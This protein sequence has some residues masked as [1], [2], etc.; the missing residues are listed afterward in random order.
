MTTTTWTGSV[1]TVGTNASNWSNGLPDATKDVVFDGTAVRNCDASGLTTGTG[2]F[3]KTLDM[4]GFVRT[5]DMGAPASHTLRMKGNCT[6][7]GAATWTNRPRVQFDATTATL[8]T[9]G[10]ELAQLVVEGPN[11]FDAGTLTLNDNAL[12]YGTVLANSSSTIAIGTTTLTLHLTD[13][14]ASLQITG[15]GSFTYSGAGK[16]VIYADYAISAGEYYNAVP[17]I[18][19][20]STTTLPPV[21][22]HGS[23]TLFIAATDIYGGGGAPYLSSGTGNVT[24]QS[25]TMDAGKVVTPYDLAGA[26]WIGL[27]TVGNFTVS[28]GSFYQGRYDA[29][30]DDFTEDAGMPKSVVVGG[31]S[32][33]SV[34]MNGT[35]VNT[36][37]LNVTGTNVNDGGGA[38]TI[39][40]INSTGT[41]LSAA[42]CVDGGGNTGVSFSASNPTVSN[43]TS[44]HA[45]GTFGLG[46]VVD[47]TV[48]FSASVTVTGTP[49]LRLALNNGTSQANYLSGSGTDTLTFRYTIAAGDNT[50]DLDYFATTSLTLNGGTINATSGGASATLTL[51]SP[52]AAGSLGANR[53]IVIETT[54]P[55]VTNVTSAHANGSFK[56]AEVIDITIDFTEAVTVTGTPQLALNSGATV[57]YFSGSGSSTLTFR[58]TVAGGQ[59]SADLDYNATSSLTLNGGTIKDAAGNNA[60]LTLAT[61]GAA[62]SLGANKAIVIDTTAPTVSNVTSAHANGSFKVG[63]VIDITVQ[64]SETVTVTGTPQLALNTGATINY[65]S[66][67]GSNTLTFRYTVGSSQNTSDLDYAATT[68]LT[69]NSGTI[70]DAAGNNAT[71]TLASPG[72]AGSLGA[73]KAIII[74]TTAPTVLNV[75]SGHADGSFKSGEVVDITVQFSESVTVTGTPQLTLALSPNRAINYISGS[76]SD[77]L[78]FRLT[79]GAPDTS[80][81]LDYAATGSLGLNGGT[82]ADAAGN[83][84]TLTLPAPGASGS[85]GANK[86]IVVDTTGPTV[87]NVTSAKTNGT[88]YKDEVI[89][90]TVQFSETVIVTGTPQLTLALSPSRAINYISGSG[91]NTLT[92][93]LTVTQPDYSTDLD[94]AAAGSLGLNGGTIVDG[95]GNNAV[96]T[97][98]TPGNAGSLG[99]NKAL[100]IDAVA[101]TVTDVTSSHANGICTPGT[102]IDIQ[103]TL[104]KAV[105]VTGTPKLTLSLGA[106]TNQASYLSGSG[107]S[108]LTFRYTTVSGNRSNDLDYAATNSL[109]LNGGTITGVNTLTAV[110]TLPAPGAAGS[111]GANKALVID[112]APLA[113]AGPDQ[114]IQLPETCQLAGSSSDVDLDSLTLLWTKV[115]GPGDATFDDATSATPIAS[116]TQDGAYVLQLASSDGV[117]TTTDTVRIVVS[118]EIKKYIVN[119]P[120]VTQGV[121]TVI[122]A[123]QT[124]E[125]AIDSAASGYSFIPRS[126][127]NDAEAVDSAA[128]VD[129]EGLTMVVQLR[130]NSSRDITTEFRYTATISDSW[131]DMVIAMAALMAADSDLTQTTNQGNGDLRIDGNDQMGAKYI[132]AW[133]EVNGKRIAHLDPTIDAVGGAH[134]DRNIYFNTAKIKPYVISIV[135]V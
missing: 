9:D 52:G 47:V 69:L 75:T 105:V 118:G 33:I 15:A 73:N 8:T 92:F 94:Y 26:W 68:S 120:Q 3:C 21:E 20:P 135:R 119:L 7:E 64:F 41:A 40:K 12:V 112:T 99:A 115:S 29:D 14:F 123:A 67:S 76:G 28:A 66:G 36:T 4:T 87:S 113:D 6:L 111:I 81:D 132:D 110:L 50:S 30:I 127:W 121:S 35:S 126:A 124:E 43:V 71:L 84:A 114:H 65:L 89:D 61:P 17:G 60:T 101:P 128:D 23:G 107:G 129:L 49:Q 58:Y 79:V 130:K 102:V 25:F 77:T 103:V 80:S 63:E 31:N 86:A 46:E 27:H 96:L 11:G 95:A 22:K 18:Y 109:I 62:G 53:A 93:R 82:I 85:L 38:V 57:N 56:A 5:I 104:T 37:T 59:T 45:N 72:A 10:V 16:I 106:G 34:S 54:A 90:I 39:T 83:N 100:V 125:A 19:V 2:M 13:Q 32:L 91:S 55:T 1:S 74:D 97:L 24:M 116:F 131:D 122:T 98:P 133:V 42:S 70:V 88:Y 134:I 117:I 78:T 51:A 44:A 108:T 48:Q